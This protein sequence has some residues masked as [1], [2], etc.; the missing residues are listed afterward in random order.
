MRAT[1]QVQRLLVVLAL[2]AVVTGAAAQQTAKKATN[3]NVYKTANSYVAAYH[4]LQCAADSMPVPASTAE[5]AAIVSW[6]YAKARAGQRV[7]LRVSRPKFHSTATFVCPVAPAPIRPAAVA[8]ERA[9]QGGKAPLEIAILQSKLNKVL[10]VDKQKYTMRVGAGMRVTELLPAATK[11]GMSMQIGSLP[12]YAGL[13]LAGILATSAHGS[14]DRT[15]N[16]LADTVLAVTWVDGRGR[17]R[18]STRKDPEF[19]AFNGGVGV[20]GVVTELLLQMTP[21]SNTQLITV[22]KDDKDMMGEINR[23]LKISPHILIHWRPDAAN[24]K[25]F[26]VRP[27][28]KGARVTPGVNMT[29]L[30]S[31]ADQATMAPMF[32]IWHT[33]LG[34]DSDMSEFLCPQVTDGSVKAAWASVKG[35]RVANVTGPTNNLAASECDEHCTWNDRRVFNGTAQDA[36]FTIEFEQLAGWIADVKR[37]FDVELREGGKAKYRCLGLGYMWIRFGQGYDGITATTSGMKRP[38][39]VQSTWMRS[40]VGPLYQMRYQFV[41]DL[42]EELTLC[43]YKGRPH[44]GKNFDRTFT[45]PKC[46]V[47]PLYPKFGQLLALSKQHDP[48]G[49]FKTKLFDRMVNQGKFDLTPRCSALNKCYC[50]ADVHCAAG[51]KCVPSLAFP[52]YKLCKAAMKN[53]PGSILPEML[54]AAVNAV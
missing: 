45:H 40:R 53:E 8:Q 9:P 48:A 41:L 18:T 5:V 25:A 19:K 52:R 24:F 44:W 37:A 15:T 31:I 30:P 3:A 50:S 39:Y 35:E 42:I 16:N 1:Q 23:L 14:G 26:L 7:T 27:A 43:K 2:F 4:Y 49:M 17:I 54:M 20:F 47:A 36:E 29:V 33:T 51:H 34:D 6:Y 11:A 22:M 28:P 46:P 21:P 32:N 10:A 13:T 38:V 12:A